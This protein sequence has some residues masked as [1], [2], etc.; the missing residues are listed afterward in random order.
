MSGLSGV[1]FRASITVHQ[2]Q[3]AA[4]TFK[5]NEIVIIRATGEQAKVLRTTFTGGYILEGHPGK[6]FHASALDKLATCS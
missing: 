3:K 4:D 6:V 2:L 5:P 1:A